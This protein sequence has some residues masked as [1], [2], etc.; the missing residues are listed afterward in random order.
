MEESNTDKYKLK[1]YWLERLLDIFT[2]KKLKS[3][4][5]EIKWNR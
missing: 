4:Y 5:Y 1:T 2:T 3:L